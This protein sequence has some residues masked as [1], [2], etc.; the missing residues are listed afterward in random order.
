MS[1]RTS[2]PIPETGPA[3]TSI[4]RR[5]IL[6]FCSTFP[7]AVQPIHGVFVKERVRHVAELPECD[8]RVV[9]PVPYFPPIRA[10]RRWY[11]LSQIPR[12]EVVDGLEVDRPRYFLLPKLGA[13]FH[14]A[15]M[16]RAS[17]ASVAR[18]EGEG[19]FDLID[20]HFVY[21]DGV[22]AARLAERLGKPLVLTGR[23]EDILR[24]PSLPVVGDQI[25]WAIGRASA[26]VAL[27]EEIAEAMRANGAPQD[28]IHVIPNG[29][30]CEKFRPHD[31]SEA[32]RRLGLPQD[33][34]IILSVGYRLERKGFHLL[35]DA[36]PEI[37]RRFPNVLVVIVGGQARWGQDYTAVIEERIR[38]SDVAD[39]VRLVGPRPPEELPWWY[40]A[41]DLFALLTSREGCPNVV[42]EALACGLPVAATPIGGIPEILADR[43]LGVVLDERSAAAA[44]RGVTDALAAS[45]EP[46]AIC[47]EA[48][49]RSWQATAERI[50]HV[51]EGVVQSRN[52]FER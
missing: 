22:A 45:W 28:K 13:Y 36:I 18:L 31:R 38:L 32:R 39:H 8:V 19:A 30:D 35:I 43:R 10:F 27:S 4:R 2:S 24:F 42:M 16:A 44:A 23:G 12:R 40:S 1:T 47:G 49:R 3:S 41:A 11:P 50:C 33:R 14:P 25:R 37:R 17:Y 26:L 15:S 6:V 52:C 51:F 48:R 5:R 7:S 20:S 21:P 34:P 29:V 9:S 46:A